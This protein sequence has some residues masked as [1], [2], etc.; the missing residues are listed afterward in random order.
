MMFLALA[1]QILM[2]IV[3]ADAVLSF[4]A[5]LRERFPRNITSKITEPLYRPIHRVLDPKKT[6]NLDLA[7]MV[8][9]VGIQLLRNFIGA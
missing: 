4:V 2:Y 3:I 1:L 6:G 7:P 5:P 8:V 9:I